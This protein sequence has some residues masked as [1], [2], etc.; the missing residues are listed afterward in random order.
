MP[1]ANNI[2]TSVILAPIITI[3][4]AVSLSTLQRGL[5]WVSSVAK[6]PQK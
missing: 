4:S 6:N 1:V 5:E 2:L 3:L